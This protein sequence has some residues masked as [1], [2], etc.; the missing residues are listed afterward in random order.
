MERNACGKDIKRQNK[1]FTAVFS[2]HLDIRTYHGKFELFFQ[3]VH[4]ILLFCLIRDQS[5]AE[6][7]EVIWNNKKFKLL[8]KLKNVL[9]RCFMLLFRIL[10]DLSFYQN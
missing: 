7:A 8:S 6:H 2:S 10:R 1:L 9:R 3:L 5:I 4:F